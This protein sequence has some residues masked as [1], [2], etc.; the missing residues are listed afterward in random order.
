LPPFAVIPPWDAP[1]VAPPLPNESGLED[2]QPA[3]A[4][5]QTALSARFRSGR[6]FFKGIGS[7]ER[8]EDSQWQ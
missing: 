3:I 6:E 2:E 8:H 1:P 4:S 7:P 5:S